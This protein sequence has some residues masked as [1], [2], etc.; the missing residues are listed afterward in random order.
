MG[1]SNNGPHLV[2]ARAVIVFDAEVQK[3]DCTTSQTKKAK[4]TTSKANLKLILLQGSSFIVNK[5]CLFL[6]TTFCDK[7]FLYLLMHYFVEYIDML[8][9]TIGRRTLASLSCGQ[10]I[11]LK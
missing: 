9:Q 11:S 10:A 1:R 5:T 2:I 7:I 8:L 4:I 6:S 3:L